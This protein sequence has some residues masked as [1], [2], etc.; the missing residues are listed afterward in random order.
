MMEV[1]RTTPV[2]PE[3]EGKLPRKSP[4]NDESS[5]NKPEQCRTVP[6]TMPN[7]DERVGNHIL[8]HYLLISAARGHFPAHDDSGQMLRVMGRAGKI[9]FHDGAK[10][11]LASSSLH[12]RSKKFFFALRNFRSRGKKQLSINFFSFF[13]VSY[14]N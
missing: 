2:N 4:N 11:S 14:E 13:K 5:P 12:I 7:N 9:F 3:Q 10:K 8:V 6:G 1:L